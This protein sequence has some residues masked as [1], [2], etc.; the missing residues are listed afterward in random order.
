M[1]LNPFSFKLLYRYGEK[2]FKEEYGVN[3]NNYIKLTQINHRFYPKSFPEFDFYNGYF[4][5]LNIGINIYIKQLY[6]G[7]IIYECNAD[8]VDEKD[9]TFITTPISNKKCK[10]KKSLLN[11]LFSLDGTRIISGYITPDS[12]FDIYAE[13]D[14]KENTNI[15]IS[16]F[17]TDVLQKNNTAKYLR[18]NIQYTINF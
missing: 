14:D 10:N 1:H 6:G 16:H 13:I 5:N 3:F 7:S 8:D 15:E 18:K 12:C 2:Y 11:R 9:L 17:M 4:N